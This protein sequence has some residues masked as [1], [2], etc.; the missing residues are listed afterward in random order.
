[1]NIL[2]SIRA[3]GD[4]CYTIAM[5]LRARH[6]SLASRC[7][8]WLLTF[9]LLA[10]ALPPACIFRSGVSTGDRKNAC[11]SII[12]QSPVA[13]CCCAPG[14]CH[15][16]NCAGNSNSRS[17]RTGCRAGCCSPSVPALVA[18]PVVRAILPTPVAYLLFT[19]GD[20]LLPTVYRSV[21]AVRAVP[22]PEQPPRCDC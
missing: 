9:A 21:V 6:L 22:A 10:G 5:P 2:R 20:W 19:S 18:S 4:V 15:M 3:N 12:S 11:V 8:L 14:T 16:A 13:Q 17:S 1:M 7:H